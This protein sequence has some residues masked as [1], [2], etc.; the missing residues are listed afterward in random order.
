[1]HPLG[2]EID[3]FHEKWQQRN[4][5]LFGK[6]RVDRAKGFIIPTTV[7]GGQANLHQQRL[8]VRLPANY[9]RRYNEAFSAI[10]PALA[11]EFDIPLLPFFMEEVYLKPQWMQD[12][13]IHPNRDAQPFI[14]DWM[15]TR[16]APLVN[17]DS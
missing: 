3:L 12:D 1:M 7:V 13:G 15:A 10:Y 9:G 2:F 11:K 5:K 6:L 14:A 17:H 4:I 16:L 8:G